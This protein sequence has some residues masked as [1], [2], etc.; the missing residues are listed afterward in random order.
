MCGIA[1][2]WFPDARDD[3]SLHA[4]G[5]RQGEAIAHR[6]PDDAGTWA[7]PA[8]GLVLSHRRLSILDL[9]PEGHQ[10]MLTRDG[11]WAL[12]F[13][14]EIYNH[15]ALRQ[16][17]AALGHGFRGHSDTEVLLAAISEWGV[18]QALQ[19]SN[20]MLAIAA[21]DRKQRRLW[22]ARDR[23]GKKPLYYGFAGDGA[24]VFG[25]E[26]RAL[27]A[28]PA[29]EAKVDPDALAL[30]LRLDYI[31]APWSILR[32]VHK[33]P[34]GSLV[35]LDTAA[36]R[37]GPASLEGDAAPRRWWDA[38]AAQRE[39]IS[40]GFAG[41]DQEALDTLDVLLRDA[42]AMRMEADVQLG[43]FLSGGT[44]SSLVTALMQAQSAQP[45]RSFSI[46]FDSK[47][48]DE[49]EQAA[50]VAAHLGTDHTPLH[51]DGQAAL[52]LVPALPDIYDEPFADSSQVPTALLCALTRKH[53]TV[54]LSGDG[55]DELFFGYSR[56]ARTLRNDAWLQRLPRALLANRIAEPGEE[57]RLGGLAALKAEL[58]AGDL[59]GLARHRASR[60]RTPEAV[61]IGAR[62]LRTAYD[63]PEAMPGVGT[64]ADALMAMDIA[65]FL[66]EDILA[67]V[68][69][70]SMAT[71]LEVR[72][73]FLDWRV[74]SFA[75]TLPMAMRSRRGQLKWLP[76]QLLQRY[77]PKTVV[78]HPKTGFGAPM[79]AWLHG[80]LRGWAEA[81]LDETRLREEGHFD[82]APIRRI[83]KAFLDGERKWHTHLWGVLM[84]Q[85]WR[86]KI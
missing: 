84:F 18:E 83:W 64:A 52:A 44:D 68:D 34:A 38:L 12:V 17:L 69:R 13:N 10:P 71:S 73:P 43:A 39:A 77:L 11:R 19:R 35:C 57:A 25:S 80:P 59:Q 60:W 20:G 30:L 37:A 42:T 26:L 31:P 86:E 41:G 45:V 40:H 32:G 63:D 82:P 75:W 70:A 47:R 15:G 67:K 27:R 23:M 3:A 65:C 33:L 51:V 16:E 62:R 21:W 4:L 50:R 24:L 49:S 53:V 8:A 78:D 55:G 28:H 61:V 76:R 14:G 46:G 85:A 79:G 66:P 6:G 22:L 36:L 1:G 56:Y 54:A 72:A 5:A 29:L 74:A 81:Q 2:T 58:R 9:S 7:D 48:H